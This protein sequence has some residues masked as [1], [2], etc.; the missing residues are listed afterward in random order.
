MRLDLLFTD[1][2][3]FRKPRAGVCHL[4]GQPCLE[5]PNTHHRFWVFLAVLFHH[6]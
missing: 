2:P 4:C 6:H 3:G 5:H 1:Q